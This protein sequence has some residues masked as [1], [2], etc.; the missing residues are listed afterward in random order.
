ME[1]MATDFEEILGALSR[2]SVDFVVVGGVAVV[3]Q[4]HPRLTADL[5]LVVRLEESNARRAIDA[6]AALQFR[7]RIPVPV[8]DFA[9]PAERR[10]WADE[11]ELVV[12]SLWSPTFP[13]TDVDLFVEE[14]IPFGELQGRSSVVDLGD[15]EVAVASVDDLIAMKQ[16]A[17]RPKDL[18][19]VAE[20]QKLRTIP[21]A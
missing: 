10:R 17:G 7:P 13:A 9:N 14:P 11:K 2:A 4:G 18:E 6:L 3:L 1:T 8:E 5:D 19:D 20:L 15:T 16:R 12:L 21:K